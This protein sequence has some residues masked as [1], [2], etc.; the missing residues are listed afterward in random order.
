M[1]CHALSRGI[2]RDVILC[3]RVQV[4]MLAHMD[5]NYVALCGSLLADEVW[6]ALNSD[7]RL[8]F[9]RNA[10]G[11]DANSDC[12]QADVDDSQAWFEVAL[13]CFLPSPP[14]AP[15][16]VDPDCSWPQEVWRHCS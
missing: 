5:V 2:S 13:E 7:L 1:L 12:R 8:K 16:H 3:F 4:H 6:Y 10:F 11:A 15:G 14:T 9:R